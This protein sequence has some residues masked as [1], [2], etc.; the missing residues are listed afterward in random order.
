[1]YILKTLKFLTNKFI[2]INY[3]HIQ[4]YDCA[5]ICLQ[6]NMYFLRLTLIYEILRFSSL[7]VSFI[8]LFHWT[9]DNAFKLS[10]FL[11]W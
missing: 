10:T 4:V 1:M 2:Y 11:V 5:T 7:N 9:A 6:E 8:L 3:L